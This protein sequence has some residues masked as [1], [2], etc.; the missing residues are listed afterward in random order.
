VNPQALVVD[1]VSKRFRRMSDGFLRR[2]ARAFGGPSEDQ[3][4]SCFWAVRDVTFDVARGEALGIIGPN[5]AG[6]STILKLL[7]GILRP[8]QGRICCRGR[9]SALIELGAGFH[10]ELTGSENVRLNAAILGVTQR[11]IRAR[12]DEVADFA[13][14]RGF[15]D[16]PVKHYS[17]GMTARLGFSI[18]AHVDP[19]VLLVDE[20]LSV[21]DRVFRARCIDCMNAFLRQGTSIVFVSHDLHTVHGF[22]SRVLLLDQG[23]TAYLGLP[24]E[25]ITR[26]QRLSD[27][28]LGGVSAPDPAIEVEYARI[29]DETGRERTD[30][31]A[32]QSLVVEAALTVRQ[33]EPAAVLAVVRRA[34]ERVVAQMRVVGQSR[35]LRVRARMRAN[36]L[37]GEYEFSFLAATR[38]LSGRV[39]THGCGPRLLVLGPNQA[40]GVADL[41]PQITVSAP[42]AISL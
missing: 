25:A 8:T 2:A 11:H 24:T 10:P 31:Q 9:M 30:I 36:L 38:D 1:S 35:R 33:G 41:R 37:P 5:G 16:L 20:V 3:A 13:D 19:E 4:A 7:A 27:V 32:G 6:K 15:M 26:Y 40:G 21:G 22:C 42:N 39:A 12:L 29:V 28:A 34:D 17:S 23:Q 18:A 14:L